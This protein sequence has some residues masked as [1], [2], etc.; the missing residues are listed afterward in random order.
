MGGLKIQN[1]TKQKQKKK[2]KEKG[3]V[4]SQFDE[5]GEAGECCV[6][7][8]SQPIVLQVS[9]DKIEKEKFVRRERRKKER[10]KV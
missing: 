3:Q 10:K 8:T 4:S 1:K 7:K 5:I 6:V 2:G 9:E